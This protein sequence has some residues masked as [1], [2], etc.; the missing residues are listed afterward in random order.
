M[1]RSHLV[2]K[3]I[4]VTFIAAFIIP[5]HTHAQD[6]IDPAKSGITLERVRQSVNSFLDE[7]TYIYDID[8]IE[9][10]PWL[11]LITD[12]L[13]RL[14]ERWRNSPL[15]ADGVSNIYV[16]IGNFLV[17]ILITAALGLLIGTFLGKTGRLSAT[18]ENGA[19]IRGSALDEWA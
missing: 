6:E 16:I 10:P 1:H 4:V 19:V 11:L 12:A 9:D 14:D 2:K 3:I 15:M 13:K 5:A 18:G 7:E 17:V 8:E